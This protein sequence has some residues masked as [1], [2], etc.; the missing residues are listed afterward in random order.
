MFDGFRDRDAKCPKCYGKVTEWQTK[1]LE[2]LGE[3]WEKGDFVQY[4]KLKRIPE[5]GRK[6]KHGDR[7][8][9]LFQ[10]SKEYL[11][12]APVLF[13]GK[14][15]VHMSCEKCHA[16]LEGYAKILDGRFAGIVEAEADVKPKRRVL[17]K[18]QITAHALKID[19]ERRLSQLQESCS[20]RKT[21][22]IDVDWAPVHYYGRALICLRCEKRL[23][24][25]PGWESVRPLTSKEA[26]RL[27]SKGQKA[28]KSFFGINRGIGPF[29]RDNE[30]ADHK[31]IS[32]PERYAIML[33]M[34]RHRDGVSFSQLASAFRAN[35]N[36]L[37]RHLKTLTHA[38]LV[39]NFYERREGRDHSFYK[40][41]A[42]G[43]KLLSSLKPEL[44]VTDQKSATRTPVSA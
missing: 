9:P 29:T 12:D 32:D 8:F 25:K 18:R 44:D 14:I 17:I 33:T 20:H 30:M 19:F 37:S 15:P 11:S 26:R 23:K 42:M 7:P 28:K 36:T 4:R 10:T 6:R 16:W 21:K 1:D 34:A 31:A 2:R 40:L 41:S 24:I 38:T 27:G 5:K 22:W 35:H 43:E 3:Y 13:N 39:W